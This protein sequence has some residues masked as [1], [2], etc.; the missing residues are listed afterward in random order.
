MKV[1]FTYLALSVPI[2]LSKSVA[3]AHT[4]RSEHVSQFH[5]F[6]HVLEGSA[7]H[8]SLVVLGAFSMAVLVHF[9]IKKNRV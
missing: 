6:Y 2:F 3:F 8:I 9:N 7:N 1:Y 4:S 5:D